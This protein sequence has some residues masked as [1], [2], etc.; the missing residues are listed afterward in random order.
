MPRCVLYARLPEQFYLLSVDVICDEVKDIEFI[1]LF[2][3]F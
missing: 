3:S 1:H 2:R